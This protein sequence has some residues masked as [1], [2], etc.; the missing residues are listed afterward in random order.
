MDAG[1]MKLRFDL[2]GTQEGTSRIDEAT[3]LVTGSQTHQQ[4]KGQIKMAA[5][6]EDP[7]M[8]TVPMAI[9]TQVAAETSDRMWKDAAK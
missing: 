9:D 7:P 4:L 5:S 6:A 3:G 1:G 2:S 8:M